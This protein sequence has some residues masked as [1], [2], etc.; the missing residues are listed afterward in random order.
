M[1]TLLLTKS[2][3]DDSKGK[4]YGTSVM[5]I[6]WIYWYISGLNGHIWVELWMFWGIII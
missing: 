3:D 2:Y 6:I 1:Q 4:I 5:F